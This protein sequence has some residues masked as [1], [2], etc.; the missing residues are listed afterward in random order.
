MGEDIIEQLEEVRG[1]ICRLRALIDVPFSAIGG[2]ALM[3]CVAWTRIV[4]ATI[5]LRCSNSQRAQRSYLRT[6]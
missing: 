1:A 5:S 4:R 6:Q 2:G 3:R